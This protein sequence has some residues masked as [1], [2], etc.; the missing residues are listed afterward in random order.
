[1]NRVDRLVGILTTLQSRKF[2]MAAPIAEQFGISIRTVYRDI[3][4]LERIGIPISF[5]ANRGYFIVPGYF[6]PPVSF[7]PDEANA[8]VIMS[9]M[10]SR[11]GDAAVASNSQSAVRKVRAILRQGDKDKS[12]DL[13]DRVKVLNDNPPENKYLYDVQN[14]I[15]NRIILYIEYTD[16]RKAR[17]KREIEPIGLIYYT[18]QWHIIAWCWKRHDYRDFKMRQVSQLHTTNKAFKKKKHQTIEEHLGTWEK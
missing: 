11:F 2:L 5:E 7:T 3:R 9:A 15:T 13:V 6:L 18:E 4:A 8:L 10:A 12:A 14:A 1:M 17:T 16:T